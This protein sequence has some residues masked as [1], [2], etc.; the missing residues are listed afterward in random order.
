MLINKEANNFYTMIII[1]HNNIS[2]IYCLTSHLD[3]YTIT[4]LLSQVERLESFLN[5]I[6]LLN[7]PYDSTACGH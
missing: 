4:L 6:F 7:V 3:M 2:Y 1:L 5:I